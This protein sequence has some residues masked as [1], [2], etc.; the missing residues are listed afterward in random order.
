MH[1]AYPPIGRRGRRFGAEGE[2]LQPKSQ[3]GVSVEVRVRSCRLIV[4]HS[5]EVMGDD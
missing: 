1:R 2:T 4:C 5:G 3:L